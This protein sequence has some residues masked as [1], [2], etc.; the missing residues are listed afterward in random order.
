MASCIIQVPPGRLFAIRTYAGVAD[1]K[2]QL[3]LVNWRTHNEPKIAAN[4][5]IADGSAADK[6]ELLQCRHPYQLDYIHVLRSR[7]DYN[8]IVNR[9]INVSPFHHSQENP[10]L[11]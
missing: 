2:A 1:C 7:N 8:L 6:S 10:S 9:P 11:W 4:L 5:L 3:R